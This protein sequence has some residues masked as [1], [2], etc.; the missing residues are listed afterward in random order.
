MELRRRPGALRSACPARRTAHRRRDGRGPP[1]S[2]SWTMAMVDVSDS[3]LQGFLGLVARNVTLVADA[4]T[5]ALTPGQSFRVGLISGA[6]AGTVVDFVLFP[7]DT[8]KTRL[9]AGT[10][11]KKGMEIMQGIYRGI[12]PAVLAS[13]PSAAAFFGSY[14]FCKNFLRKFNDTEQ[15]APFT[16]MLGAAVGDTA[17]SAVRVPFEV[18][19][20][21]LQAGSF[22]S[23]GQAVR[24]IL[25]AE[26]VRGLFTGY[27]SLVMREM[28][29]DI[30]EFPLYEAL[31][32]EWAKRVPDGR[33]ATWQNALC[34][35]IAGAFAS[36]VTTPLDVV[37]TRLM[38]QGGSGKYAGVLSALRTIYQEE[39]LGALYSGVVPRV[40]WISLGGFIFFGGYETSKDI[41]S[42][43]I[44]NK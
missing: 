42:K 41:L 21:R 19:K 30:I 15:F 40:M 7:L 31:K 27:G 2:G 35:S 44:L 3:P 4:A 12:V 26:G 14:D 34:G 36:A 18:V 32:K 23:A 8:I 33:L 5:D 11:A 10:V 20:Q 25:A 6:T 43:R 38:L 29:F 9:Q 16:H 37:K 39:G 17:S 13:A 1:E 22:A 24:A 28:P